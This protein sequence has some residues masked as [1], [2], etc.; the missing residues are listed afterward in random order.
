ME[1]LLIM[2]FSLS[3]LLAA[4]TTLPAQSPTGTVAGIVT[5]AT[6]AVMPE[7]RIAIVHRETG[8]SRN[9][10]TD[11]DGAYAAASLPVGYYEVR[12]E[13]EGF[14]TLV[15]Q[16]LV[17]AGSNTRV[18]LSLS[19]EK[20]QEDVTIETALP[21]IQHESHHI[22]GV[23][24]RAQIESLPLNG[25]SFY[26]LAKLEPGVQPA[27]RGSNNRTFVPI[28]GAPGG[29][30]GRA[31]RVTIDGG[32]V[33]AIGNGG[34]AMGL[35]QEVVEE[36]QVSTVNFELTTGLTD[37]GALNVI[38]RSG[39]NDAHGTAFYFFRDHNLSAYPALVRDPFNP[40]PFFQRRQFGFVLGGPIR[41][42][43]VFFF[44]NWERNEQRSVAGTRV[45]VPDFA[46]L[47]RITPS[48]LFG[49][50]LSV[51]LDGRLGNAHSGFVRYSHDGSRA[52][53][54]SSLF[55]NAPYPSNWTRQQAW[56][57]QSVLGLTSVPGSTLVNDFRFSYFFIS[58]REV[59]PREEDCPA[60]LGIG[61]PIINIAQAGLQIG[62]SSASY[63]LARR[64]HLSDSMTWQAGAHRIRFGGDWEY[65]RGGALQWLSEP[66]TMTLFSPD[67]VRR[68]NAQP[69]TPPELRIPLPPA[70]RTLDD[71]LQ[72]P[73]ANFTI[74][75]GDPR[76]AQHNGTTTRTWSVARLFVQDAWRLHPRLTANYG[77]GWSVD[78]Y[79]NYD[80]TKPALLAPVL[81]ADG[82]G[83]RRKNWTNFSPVLGFAWAPWSDGK[84]VFRAGA[85]IFYDF[86]FV[87]VLDGERALLGPPGLGRQDF[88]GSS[89]PNP[90]AN[91]PGVPLGSPL[92]FRGNP[93]RFTG[94][95]LMQ[96]LP[97]TRA[98]LAQSLAANRN[99]SVSAVEITKQ[100]TGQL[101]GL[102]YASELPNPSA[103]HANVGLQRE[104]ARNFVL[105]ADFAYRHFIHLGL[106]GDLNR[107]NSVR[108]PVIPRCTPSQAN[109]PKA[110]CSRGAINV[111]QAGANATNKGL[112]LRA[113]KRF[114]NRFQ[115]LGS[116]AYSS[117]T[118]TQAV[119]LD[120]RLENR[121]PLD[122]D[123]THIANL[124]GVVQMPRRLE[125]GFN[126]SYSS[127]PPFNAF[128]GGIDFNGDG[129]SNDA[130]P[131]AGIN[132]FNRGL[133]HADLA[134][135]VEQFNQTWAD[136]RDAFGRVIPRL[137]LPA[138]YW[139]GDDFHA[140][141]LR[142]SR[143]FVFRERWRLSIIGEVF[144]AYN[145]ANL[146]GHNGNLI[147]AA[148]GQ[149]TTRATQIF[150]SGGPRA[151]QLVTKV[152]F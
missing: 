102:L 52:V 113:D 7:V 8:L 131:G 90:L 9:S 114:S 124:G 116:Y 16:A 53:G 60:C 36:F 59:P 6:G 109:D 73:L 41:R 54:P 143:S 96:I 3:I 103:L 67:E 64:F 140:L 127:A 20:V 121:G 132:Q 24:T 152:G 149:P 92:E 47:S 30:S 142:L 50:Q 105:S 95:H 150:G 49:N 137:T 148:F 25:R 94:A 12:A 42:D 1:R 5:D 66:V 89:I 84:T 34:A 151:F 72:L 31:T 18:D 138:R 4:G 119:N 10:I 48:P 62:N 77:L 141:D 43:R 101:T 21:Q 15:R 110:Q 86:F 147:N 88:V 61:A 85:G 82:L 126:F 69:Q 44:A 83:P 2:K 57:D 78:G 17:E 79:G 51:R 29:N 118:G 58:S 97:A 120:N 129:T 123:Y 70:F 145:A 76:V 74:G 63:N 46:H 39:A 100:V 19:V 26:E 115:M 93:S 38:T 65:H 108:G 40:D 125:L 80:L 117:N 55:G 98:G 99:S 27:S 32:S 71:V 112:L 68:Y 35:S 14:S 139:F 122:R 134:R 107:F 28:L 104:I 130:L 146:S 106:A 11:A 33:M 87:P 133:G 91:I 37:S 81:G 144:N 13:R 128:V 111:Q 135:L 136:K 45:V 23:V 56:A 22:G 75:I